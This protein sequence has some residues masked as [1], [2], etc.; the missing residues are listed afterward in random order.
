[1][2]GRG[3]SWGLGTTTGGSL[4][5]SLKGRWGSFKGCWADI[6]GFTAQLG[7]SWDLGTTCQW[8]Y[9]RTCCHPKWPHTGLA[10][11]I[12]QV[13]SPFMSSY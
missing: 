13:R 5:G 4:K 3:A 6:S 10:A 2:G 7:G 12:R 11:G 8:A 1:M 9:N